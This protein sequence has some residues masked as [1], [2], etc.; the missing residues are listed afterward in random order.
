MFNKATYLLTYLLT[1]M[2]NCTDAQTSI[3]L[4]SNSSHSRRQA[5][6][7]HSVNYFVVYDTST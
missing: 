7:K 2:T 1:Y 5:A 4:V 3:I 6:F